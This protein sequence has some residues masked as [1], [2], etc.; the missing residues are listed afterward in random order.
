[1][2]IIIL[3]HVYLTLS[4]TLIKTNEIEDKN[5]TLSNPTQSPTM[6]IYDRSKYIWTVTYYIIYK[7]NF[8]TFSSLQQ[9]SIKPK[10]SSIII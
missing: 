2:Y 9:I 6:R 8:L 3:V 7:T 1:M 10:F 5:L 4:E